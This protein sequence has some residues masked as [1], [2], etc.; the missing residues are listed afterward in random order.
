MGA[1]PIGYYLGLLTSE[2]QNAPNLKAYLAFLLTPFDD[3][4]TCL[5]GANAAYDPDLA[6]GSQL[7]VIGQLVGVG[8]TITAPALGGAILSFS[9]ATVG[10]GYVLGDVVTI[11]QGGASGGQLKLIN[12]GPRLFWQLFAP[13]TGYVTAS[14]LTVTGGSGTGLTVNV[15][16]SPISTPINPV[17][18][19]DDYRILLKAKIGQN[20]WDGTI[21][22]LYPLW[23]GLFPGGLIIIN[24]NQDMTATIFLAGT[25]SDLV[26]TMIVNGL[27]VPRPEGVLYNYVFGE[28]PIFGFGRSDAFVAGWGLGHWA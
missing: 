7:D 15:S 5:S 26:I 3:L 19:D 23:Q 27:I 25:F 2:Y 28:M 1:N 17:L 13:G 24:D 8:R 14:G 12:F 20:E 21:D 10:S 11:V 6:V 9:I 16:A 22:S 4:N 18:G